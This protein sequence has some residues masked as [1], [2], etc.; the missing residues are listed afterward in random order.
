MT[1][2]KSVAPCGDYRLL[3]EL[4]N[5]HAIILDMECKLGTVRFGMLENKD[6][7]KRVYTD[8]YSIYWKKGLIRL[9]LS[10]I[11]QMLQRAVAFSVVA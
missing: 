7:F 11:I 10:E 4:E 3:I 5:G 2:I 8:G 6:V 9:N 1:M